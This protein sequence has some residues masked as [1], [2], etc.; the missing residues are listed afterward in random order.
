VG[1]IG[2]RR[3]RFQLL[4]LSWPKLLL[5]NLLKMLILN[6]LKLLLN[7]FKLLLNLLK[8]LLLDWLW[9]QISRSFHP[10]QCRQL[11]RL[12]RGKRLNSIDVLLLSFLSSLRGRIVL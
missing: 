7:W 10:L 11:F 4:L 1:R 6:W 5:L 3:V 12:R 9:Y 2:F 8:M